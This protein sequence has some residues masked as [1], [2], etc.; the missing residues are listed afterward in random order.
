MYMEKKEIKVCEYYGH[1]AYYSV[2]PSEIFDAL[3]IAYLKGDEK[4]LVD[5]DLFDKMIDE[6]NNKMK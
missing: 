1:P 6:Y 3:E 2:M 4:V 5:K